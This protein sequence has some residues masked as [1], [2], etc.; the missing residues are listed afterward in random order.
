[1]RQVRR[2]ALIASLLMIAV[3]VLRD[4]LVR[5]S[6][7]EG[8]LDLAAVV[9]PDHPDVLIA[10][11]MTAIGRSSAAHQ[12]IGDNLTA[13]II[14]T[15]R[16]APLAI[17]P[18]LVQGVKLQTLGKETAAGQLFL[19]AERRDPRDRSPHFFLALHYVNIGEGRLSLTEMGKMIRLVPG[20]AGQLSLKIA[21]AVHQTGGQDMIR[22]LV[23]ENPSLRDDILLALA[24][25]AE[26]A[27]FIQS[28]AVPGSS[29]EWQPV[30][31]R[32]LVDIGQFGRAYALWAKINHVDPEYR[33]LLADPTVKLTLPPP[34]G[35][36]L[37][38]NASGVA[39]SAEE[40]GIHVIA[41]GRDVFIPASQTLVLAPGD[42]ALSFN[43]SSADGD[44]SSVSWRVSCLPAG[45]AIADIPLGTPRAAGPRARITVPSGC[46]A[47]RLDLVSIAAEVPR[48]VDLT[49][50][51]I[52]L[53]RWQ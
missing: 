16:R 27:D 22:S 10:Q 53:R 17:E 6:L 50:F 35:W 1:M 44:A 31:L 37:T 45:R 39:E 46:P 34:F 20:S 26:N 14:E 32:S 25:N 30:L 15:A 40:G 12:P 4:A 8:H 43:W 21:Q 9:W 19:A 5:S 52:N 47:Q 38:T 24:A 48:T 51:A 2:L 49:L 3:V 11:G 41:Y 36:T 28:L 29:N 42:Y 33:A 23:S 13:P 18:F 7:R